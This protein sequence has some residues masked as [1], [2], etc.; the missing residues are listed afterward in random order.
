MKKRTLALF[1]A[2]SLTL[3]LAGCG[4]GDDSSAGS[5]AGNSGGGGSASSGG[6]SSSG[7]DAVV[8]S[9]PITIKLSGAFAEGT[10]HYYYFEQFCE[11]VSERSNGSVTVIW[12]NGP[13]A[14]PA[15]QLAEA[16]QNGIVELVYSPCTYLITHS[17]GLAG[18]KM[19][20]AATMRTN[21][22][23]EYISEIVDSTLNSV[24]LGRAADASPYVLAS[25]VEITQ[26]S[27]FQGMVF[28]GTNAHKP[29]LA[30]V[31]AEMTTMGWGDVYSAIKRNVIAGVG[32]TLKDFVDNSLGDKLG[33]LIDPGFYCSDASLFIGN[34]VWAKL[35]DVQKQAIM[36]S[37]YDW[38]VDSKTFNS[39]ASVHNTQALIDAGTV[40]IEFTG[41]LREEFLQVVY[42]SA[43]AEVEATAPEIAEKMRTFTDF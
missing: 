25:S 22:G 8:E 31:G 42:D 29:A 9:T 24:Y 28:R 14:I 40:V 5:S 34:H 35:D 39:E 21:G 19:T 2:T 12:G 3:A 4:G 7:G 36:D 23:F 41:D 16:M 43:W 11:S 13:E 17:P 18:V 30:A 33:Y 37:A 6:Q 1:L 32:G 27:D 10:E 26:L 15:D 20:D 38:E